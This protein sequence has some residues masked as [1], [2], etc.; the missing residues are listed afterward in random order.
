MYYCKCLNFTLHVEKFNIDNEG[1]YVD[2]TT[3]RWNKMLLDS[4]TVNIEEDYKTDWENDENYSKAYK[5]IIPNLHFENEE[6][7]FAI[8]QATKLFLIDIYAILGC[9][10]L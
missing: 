2:N 5:L 1:H 9:I 10:S 4:R 8:E 3:A 7:V 6:S